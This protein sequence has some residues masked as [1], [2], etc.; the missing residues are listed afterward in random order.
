MSERLAAGRSK[1]ASLLCVTALI[2]CLLPDPRALAN[3]S[4][5]PFQNADA[6][7]ELHQLWSAAID[8]MLQR[9]V[10]SANEAYTDGQELMLPLHTAFH[11]RDD[12]WER[13]FSDHYSRLT[14]N[15]SVLPTVVLSRLEYLYL[16][17]E[18]LVLAQQNDRQ[19]LIPP[20]LP[21]LLFSNVQNYWRVAP[22]WQWGQKPFP[23]GIRERI[24]WKLKNHKVD[25]SY[26]RAIVDDDLFLLAIAADLKAFG[27]SAAQQQA[28]SS[29]L[30]D[31]LDVAFKVFSQEGVNQPGGGWLFQ[32]GVWVDHPEYQYA[33]NAVAEPGIRPA[34]LRGA[35]LD[36][37]HAMR[38]AAWSNSLRLANPPDGDR[39]R[40]Y[41]EVRAGLEKQFYEKALVQPSA[42]CPCYRLNNF[43]DGSNGVY[44]WNY[45]TLGNGVGYGPYQLS[46]ALLLGWWSLLDTQRI[47]DVYVDLAKQFPWQKQ[48]IDLYYLGP[49]PTHTHPDSAFDPN[50]PVMR[51]WH[52]VVQLAFRL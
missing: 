16:A 43:L 21:D 5:L 47:R 11:L 7:D 14:S 10:Q 46:G 28:W 39:F 12:A 44:R 27:G 35:G 18:F 42:D 2:V 51:L 26:Y 9:N 37:S 24:L 20:G 19:D 32:P 38:F 22:A 23:G 45:D 41:S 15:P 1:F 36:S 33:G 8:P 25:K 4:N 31:V 40:F 48:C 52:T 29:T 34:P 17:S 13:S 50:S 49:T 6:P 3:P 30:D